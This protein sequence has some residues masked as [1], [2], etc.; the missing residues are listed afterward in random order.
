MAVGKNKRVPIE[1]FQIRAKMI[2]GIKESDKILGEKAK[3]APIKVPTPLPPSPFKKIDQ[4]CP[5][6][7]ARPERTWV[8]TEKANSLA[9]K[10][11]R[12]PLKRSKMPVKMPCHLPT[13]LKTLDPEVFR[14]PISK[15]FLPVDKRV[16]IY[17]KGIEPKK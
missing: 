16:I 12:Y 9:R 15:M 17:P 2:K 6:I 13:F 5:K 4:L 3:N 7:A 14:Q 8:S 11:T 10:T 1:A